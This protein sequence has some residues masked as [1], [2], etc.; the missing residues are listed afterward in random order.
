M[1]NEVCKERKAPVVWIG[2]RSSPTITRMQGHVLGRGD[3][4]YAI[5]NC[6]DEELAKI[7]KDLFVNN[8]EAMSNAAE[9]PYLDIRLADELTTYAENRKLDELSYAFVGT[10]DDIAESVPIDEPDIGMDNVDDVDAEQD[11]LD[12]LPLPAATKSEA[13]RKKAWLGVPRRAR[14]AIRRLHRNFKHMP[15]QTLLQ[16]LRQAKAPKEYIDAARSFRCNA[17]DETKV[18]FPHN[19]HGIPKTNAEPNDDVGLDVVEIR[20]AGGQ[21]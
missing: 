6:N 8:P 2:E 5:R 14:V 13:D 9:R 18:S 17:C 16:V 10:V 20:D 3:C 4:S 7:L 21:C 12:S 11:M 1:E 15:K 19:K